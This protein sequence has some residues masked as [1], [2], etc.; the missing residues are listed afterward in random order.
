[1]DFSLPADKSLSVLCKEDI[2]S[3]LSKMNCDTLSRNILSPVKQMCTNSLE[4]TAS[5]CVVNVP[6]QAKFSARESNIPNL[7]Q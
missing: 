5:P 3:G 4:V 6:Q 2:S 7:V 1:M